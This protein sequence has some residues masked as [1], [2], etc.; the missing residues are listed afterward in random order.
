[1][2]SINIYESDDLDPKTIED[3]NEL[4][5]VWHDIPDFVDTQTGFLTKRFF[6][7][8]TTIRVDVIFENP[9]G[10]DVKKTL[11]VDHDF[12]GN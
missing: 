6:F 3:M 2:V 4:G 1:M 12:R 9:N 8:S 11:V 7:G 10:K 5:G